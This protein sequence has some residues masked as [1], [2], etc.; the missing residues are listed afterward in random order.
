MADATATLSELWGKI[1]QHPYVTAGAV[2][3]LGAILIYLYYSGGTTA[4]PQNSAAAAAAQEEEAQVQSEAVQAQYGAE[5]QAQQTQANSVAD[6][7]NGQVSIAQIQ[8]AAQTAT[9]TAQQT[10]ESQEIAAQQTVD[11]AQIAAEQAVNTGSISASTQQAQIAATEQEDQTSALVG[12]LN[13]EVG[14]QYGVQTD[15]INQA[16]TTV[17]Q[18]QYLSYLESTNLSNAEATALQ[19]EVND[20]AGQLADTQNYFQKP[21]GGAFGGEGFNVTAQYLEGLEG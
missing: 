3:V 6:Q 8:A 18:G 1:K 5:L 12:F 21:T 2:F 15:Q 11:L 20:V 17:Q 7:V 13:T 14:D 16:A 4:A 10:A 9:E 19:G